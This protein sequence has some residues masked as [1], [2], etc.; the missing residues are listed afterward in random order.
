MENRKPSLSELPLYVTH[1]GELDHQAAINSITAYLDEQPAKQLALAWLLR[2]RSYLNET[3][4]GI[5]P[6]ERRSRIND[7]LTSIAKDLWALDAM[8][9]YKD[10]RV[11]FEF[12][13]STQQETA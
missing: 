1:F 2:D 10:K 6:M 9:P 7:A 5:S 3:M 11:V 8:Q 13:A 4:S 12:P